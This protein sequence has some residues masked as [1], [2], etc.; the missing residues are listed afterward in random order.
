MTYPLS[1]SIIACD[2]EANIARC[3]RSAKGL[4]EEII[5]VDS[6]SKDRTGEIAQSFGARVIHQD[7]LGQSGQKQVA[8]NHCT[9]AWVLSLDC[10]EELSPELRQS[11]EQ[12]FSN[13]SSEKFDGAKCNRKVWFMGRWITHGVWYPDCKL[14]LFRRDKG[15]FGGNAAHD[16]VELDGSTMLLIGDLHHYSFPSMNRYIEKINPFAD[17]F[18]EQQIAQGKS[19]SLFAN[20]ARPLWRFF[21]AYILRRGFL[22]GFPGLWIAVATAFFNFVRYSRKYENDVQGSEFKVQSSR[23]GS[24]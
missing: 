6:G 17:A 19:W 22:D 7:W 15:R 8:L 2:E 20:I 24:L 12:F 4:A 9:K 23:N 16:K 3:L 5:V 14:R 1:L 11:I 21:R 10:D 13:G 18:L